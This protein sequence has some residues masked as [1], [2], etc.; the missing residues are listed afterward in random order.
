[1]SQALRTD[2]G[3]LV[4]PGMKTGFWNDIGGHSLLLWLTLAPCD[5]SA[6]NFFEMIFHFVVA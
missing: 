4:G 5:Q 3:M 2:S 6:D 1:M